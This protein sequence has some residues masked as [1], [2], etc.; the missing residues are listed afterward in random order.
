MEIDLRQRARVLLVE[1]DASIRSALELALTGEGYQVRATSDGS[2]I[3]K[4]ATQFRPDLAILDIRLPVGPDG[5]TVARQLRSGSDLPVL[6]VTAADSLEDRLAGF[7]AGADD[8]IVKPFAMAELLAR[9]QALLRRSGRVESAVRQIGDLVIDD[10]ARVVTRAGA[11]L[12]LTRREFDLLSALTKHPG[13]VLSRLQLLNMVWGSTYGKNLIEVNM[14]TLRRKLE[15]HGPRLVHTVRGVG[16][17]VR[18]D[19]ESSGGAS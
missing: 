11:T 9:V 5:Y 17:V 18:T 14:S 10:H 13:R 2:T 6:F 7:E 8:Y 19:P 15:A 4:V 16:Y 3:D 12:N 1:D